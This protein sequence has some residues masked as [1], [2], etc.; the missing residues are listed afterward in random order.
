MENHPIPQDI[1]GFQ[2]KLIGD[3]T[4]KQFAYLA[5]GTVLAWIIFSLPITYFL[6]FPISSIL[7]LFGISFAF[8][9]LE[10]R[11]M[12]TMILNFLRATFSPTKYV[13]QNP[14]LNFAYAQKQ[15]TQLSTPAQIPKEVHNKHSSDAP[16]QNELDKKEF[17]FFHMLSQML[18]SQPSSGSIKGSSQD[19]SNTNP[20]IVTAQ[21]KGEKKPRE[22]GKEPEDSIDEEKAE[23][24]KVEKLQETTEVLQEQLKAAVLE[25]QSNQGSQNYEEAHKKVLEIEKVLNE[26]LLQKQDLE[27]E[28]QDLKKQLAMQK[29][30]TF[31]PSTAPLPTTP[32][33][34]T[35]TDR[36]SA[37]TAGFP[38]ISEF[39]NLITGITKDPRGNPL[40]NIL[41]E[42]KDTEGN[43]VRAF[44]TNPLGQ[45]Q[46]STPLTNGSYTI[47]FE[48]PKA[49]SK[50]DKV[51][52]EAS[53][54]V[55]PPLEVFSIDEREEL[56]KSLF[57]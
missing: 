48:D 34:R 24:Q 40:G 49:V 7:I 5:T 41:V 46:A 43:P 23:E 30:D 11:P 51:A 37:K 47:E 4:L 52:F 54:A 33:V 18:H 56:R 29:K 53:G 26:T 8:L 27:K 28:I 36:E 6:K 20:Y 22:A 35:I 45:F 14:S 13:Y 2:F 3:M 39:P 10:G 25:E 55:I 21:V 9:S 42:V 32:N 16:P 19:S 57:N 15:N 44:K 50:F 12:D 31:A 38:S 17:D 1:T